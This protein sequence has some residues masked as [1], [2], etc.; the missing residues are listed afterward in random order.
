M[1][2]QAVTFSGSSAARRA[3]VCLLLSSD[4]AHQWT[5]A[6]LLSLVLGSRNGREMPVLLCGYVKKRGGEG[7]NTQVK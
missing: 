5:I 7:M 1:V 4:V 3:V 6:D 2:L